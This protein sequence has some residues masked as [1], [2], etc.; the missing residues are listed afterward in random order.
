MFKIKHLE[1]RDEFMMM[2]EIYLSSLLKSGINISNPD[3]FFYG[4]YKFYSFENKFVGAFD[5]DR[6]VASMRYYVS[7]TS[8]SYFI[9]AQFVDESMYSKFI[10]KQDHPSVPVINFIIEQMEKEKR[11]TWYK[12]E[13]IAGNAMF[14]KKNSDPLIYCD[15]GKDLE[16]GAARYDKYVDE[17]IEPGSRSQ[18]SAFDS[19]VYNRQW[20]YG[21]RVIQHCLKPEYRHE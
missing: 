3:G 12:S 13:T 15:M 17:I 20:E 8:P 18:N 4:F 2:K 14:I 19:L 21:L 11:Y 9:N 5:G 1:T 16:T 6:L 10:I 7:E